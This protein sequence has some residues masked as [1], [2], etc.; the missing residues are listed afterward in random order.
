MFEI[1]EYLNW[2]VSIIILIMGA[3][4]LYFGKLIADTRV[5]KYEKLNLYIEGL[6]FSTI[7]FFLPLLVSFYISESTKVP[8]YLL[9]IVD[10]F[11]L[12][13]LAL[14]VYANEYFKKFEWEEVYRKTSKKVIDKLKEKDTAKGKLVKRWE[15]EFM[16]RTGHD[17]T[18]L[19]VWIFKFS[20]KR[21][22]NKYVLL[23][24]SFIAIVSFT[25]SVYYED[26][27]TTGFMVI[28]SFFILS[29]IALAYGF[30][31]AYYPPAKIYMEGGEMLEGRVL[32]FDEYIYITKD[33]KKFFINKDKVKYVEESKF[34]EGHKK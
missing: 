8:F 16:K 10:Y 2:N 31:K 23:L 28:M 11:I 32:K 26:F 9:F 29:M 13:C 34:K 15:G 18:D 4:I 27:L 1:S 30:R 14:N 7:Y 17:Y 24:F 22:G 21:F 25:N 19:H 20:M 3:F 6:L 5:E 33:D 12:V